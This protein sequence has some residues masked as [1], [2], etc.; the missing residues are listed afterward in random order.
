MSHWR[1]L[2]ADCFY[3][4]LWDEMEPYCSPTDARMFLPKDLH[5]YSDLLKRSHIEYT[6][7]VVIK[8]TLVV[9]MK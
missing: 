6:T 8:A 5:K 7:Y 2:P 4:M 1:Q 9:P 3:M